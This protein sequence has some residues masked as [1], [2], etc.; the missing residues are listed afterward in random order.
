MGDLVAL[1]FKIIGGGQSFM[2]GAIFEKQMQITDIGFP[3]NLEKVLELKPDLI[4]TGLTDEK[5][6]ESISKIAPSLMFDT[7]APLEE[8]IRQLGDL[9]G[10]KQKAEEW[11]AAY[12]TKT[13]KMWAQLKASGMKPGETA[14]VFTYYPGN[15]LF[16]MARAG[17]PQFIYD[18]NG[19]K[20]NEKVQGV[21][22]ANKG[23]EQISLELLP[24]FAGDRIFI[25][26]PTA[27]EAKLS[28]EELMKSKLWLDLPAVKN[29]QVYYMDI[30][31]SSSDA[32]TR[33]WLI[34]ELPRLLSSKS[35]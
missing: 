29:G 22:N 30:E 34:E 33:D 12:Q 16:V 3:M 19:F 8:R 7:F 11:L 17:L 24:Q 13:E 28:T 21:L 35:K 32:A 15:K 26:N 25:L 14:T 6:F 9:I 4:I 5:A 2:K 31:K 18:K 20:T 1:D 10:K 23:F 27:D